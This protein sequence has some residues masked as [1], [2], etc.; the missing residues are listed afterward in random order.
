MSAERFFC[1][2]LFA[3]S[4]GFSLFFSYGGNF[5]ILLPFIFSECFAGYRSW[6]FFHTFLV[7]TIVLL[8]HALV[9]EVF[10]SIRKMRLN[11]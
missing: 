5:Q 9:K 8:M 7:I 1:N 10:T 3:S 4:T 11:K 2:L 6:L